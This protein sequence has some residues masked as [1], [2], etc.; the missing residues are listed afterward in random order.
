MRLAKQKYYAEI[1]EKHKFDIK[2]TWRS[3]NEILLKTKKAH[4]FPSYLMVDDEKIENSLEIAIKFNDFFVNIGPALSEKIKSPNKSFDSF[5]KKQITCTFHFDTLTPNDVLK[6]IQKLKPKSSTGHDGISTKLL[7]RAGPTLSTVLALIINQSLFSGI[8][9][10]QLKIAK[11][12]PLYKK[13]DSHVLDNYRPISLLPAL[14]KVFERV[15]FKQL[16]TY[17]TSKK[18]LYKSQYVFR[19]DH[20]TELAALE[21]IDKIS[22]DLDNGRIPIALFL[23]LSKAFDTLNHE[24]LL[25]KLKYYGIQ[26]KE[27]SWF[28]SYL[29]DRKQYVE[30][31]GSR[32]PNLTITTGVPQG[33]IL[34]PLL[35]IIY[36]NDIHEASDIFHS[37]LYA[38]D[39]T[40]ST[41][42]CAFKI[43]LTVSQINSLSTKINAEMSKIHDWL[44]INKLSLNLSKT[45]YMIF[46]NR[47]RKISH[48]DLNLEINNVILERVS[49]FNF[50]GVTI[51]E[52]LSWKQHV[53]KLANK[54]SRSI[55]VMNKLKR[56]LPSH[57]MLTLYNTMILPHLQYSILCWGHCATRI[58]KLQKK[59]VRIISHSKYN[60]HTNPLFKTLHLLKLDD[61]VKYFTVKFYYKLQHNKLPVYFEHL[62]STNAMVHT[63]HTR[64]SEN[65]HRSIV[66]TT[67]ATR[68]IR[69]SLPRL[70]PEISKSILDKI[71][72]HS[73]PGF[74]KYAK[75]FMI[76][77]YDPQCRIQNC[78]ICST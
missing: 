7:K 71:N 48:I 36:M 26:N 32:S 45:K 51:D 69:H 70:I 66:K 17:F 56:F 28:H 13:G 1:F 39:T 72:T 5:L 15:V 9:P 59:A 29:T 50:L 63:Y 61:I 10:D 74:S 8:F 43:P 25:A 24:I 73:Y 22:E 27:L 23:D 6:A 76:D 75:H 47:Q 35:F 58:S 41:P 65:L 11:I 21:F 33:S 40:L 16:Y 30:M 42:L 62:F 64:Q 20:S 19:E 18:L 60:A 78:Y 2:K 3:I 67:T 49:H 68:S 14:S 4:D 54:L 38:D 12:I 34:G 44:C 55:G 77:Q 46:H 53:C 31:D 57:I 52:H 37:I